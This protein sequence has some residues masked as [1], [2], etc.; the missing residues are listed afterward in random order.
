MIRRDAFSAVLESPTTKPYLL[1]GTEEAQIRY[2]EAVQRTHP[3]S[4]AVMRWLARKR[5]VLA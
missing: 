2:R 5:A 1:G 3:S 4:V